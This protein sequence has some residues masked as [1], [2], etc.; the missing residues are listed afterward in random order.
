MTKRKGVKEDVVEHVKEPEVKKKV[1]KA[2]YEK[3]DVIA[4]QVGKNLN[5]VVGEEKFTRI[6]SKEELL[7]VKESISTYLAVPSK[8]AFD[9]M[10][11]FI[12]PATQAKQEAIKDVAEKIKGSAKGVVTT[13]KEAVKK[14]VEKVEKVVKQVK[15]T[16]KIEPQVSRNYRIGEY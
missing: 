16:P 12:K 15:S 7:E 4:K 10:M 9:E 14:G 11:A 2:K 5:V 3:I 1:T 8:K 6:G 13:V